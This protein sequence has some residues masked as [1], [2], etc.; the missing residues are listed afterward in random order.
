MNIHD[1]RVLGAHLLDESQP[2]PLYHQIF[3]LLRDRIRSGDLG[4][5]KM[6]PGEKDL[7]KLF[8][9]SRITV[10]RAMNELAKE[11]FVTRHRGRGTVVAHITQPAVIRASFENLNSLLRLVDRETSVKLVEIFDVEADHF[12]ADH[13]QLAVG[14]TVRGIVRIRLL[15]GEPF[16]YLVHH[17]PLPIAELL[18]SSALEGQSMLEIYRQAAIAIVDTEQWI[19]AVSAEAHV[20]SALG[21][22]TGSPL[23]RIVRLMRDGNDKPVQLVT[24]H[25]HPELF[26]YHLR[27]GGS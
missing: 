3:R 23:L 10:K 20:A 25:Y 11:N 12:I 2:A 14:Q 15:K 6:L 7:A 19:S 27:T 21:I 18:D 24:G 17:I 16:S 1:S 26:Q 22:T 13:L 4:A 5:G 8:S 9:V